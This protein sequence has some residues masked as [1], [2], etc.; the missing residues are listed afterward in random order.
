[1]LRPEDDPSC[2]LLLPSMEEVERR[3]EG[4]KSGLPW[5][6]GVKRVATHVGCVCAE[7]A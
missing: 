5:G 3:G 6:P 7:L 2:L 4:R 1:M